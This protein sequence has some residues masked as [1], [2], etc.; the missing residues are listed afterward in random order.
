M[1]V[2]SS[3]NSLH[4]LFLLILWVRKSVTKTYLSAQCS[5][6][7]AV[8]K[9]WIRSSSA[10]WK[11][12]GQVSGATL[13]PVIVTIVETFKEKLPS[14]HKIKP[15]TFMLLIPNKVIIGFVISEFPRAL[16]CALKPKN[17]PPLSKKKKQVGRAASSFY[18]YRNAL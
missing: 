5:K 8:M 1:S 7:D 16:R 15:L 4:K 12:K 9:V 18:V 3:L 10:L 14:V 2:Q 11:R 13:Q 6:P 17:N